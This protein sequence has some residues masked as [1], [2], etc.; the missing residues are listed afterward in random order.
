MFDT[1]PDHARL[2]VYGFSRQLTE[3]EAGK[4]RHSFDGFIH[5]WKSHGKPVQGAYNLV[6]NRFLL[7]ATEDDT[8]GCSIDTS[9]KILKAMKD[10]HGLDALASDLVFYRDNSGIHAIE[11]FVFQ[12]LVDEGAIDD[13]TIVYNMM[14]TTVGALRNNDW[15]VPFALSWH[16]R[17]FRKSA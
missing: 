2:W 4:V 6:D 11:R 9:V 12:E 14:I 8:S 7:L 3:Q 1:L 16:R 15:E 5:N 13:N 17:A 10:Q